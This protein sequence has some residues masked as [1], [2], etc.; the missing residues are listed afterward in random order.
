MEDLAGDRDLLS[1]DGLVTSMKGEETDG[2]V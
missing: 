2:E 1:Y